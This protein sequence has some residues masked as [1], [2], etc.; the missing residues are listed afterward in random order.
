MQTVKVVISALLL[1]IAGALNHARSAEIA[2]ANDG[3]ITIALTDEKCALNAVSNLPGRATWD[4]KGK[5][6]EGC[7]G[8][9][10]IFVILYFDDKSVVV[11][12][13]HAFRLLKEV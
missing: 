10:K 9:Q 6:Y 1:I 3:D 8:V 13:A 11:L 5:H 4:E 7:F 12:P 2:R